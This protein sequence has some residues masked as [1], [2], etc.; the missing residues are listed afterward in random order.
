M[1][2]AGITAAVA[3]A[4]SGGRTVAIVVAVVVA[5]AVA[6]VAVVAVAMVTVVGAGVG[7][8]VQWRRQLS[9]YCG[10]KG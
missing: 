4:I 8:V 5:V 10:G 3:R 9:P 2:I 1:A 6:V 7:A